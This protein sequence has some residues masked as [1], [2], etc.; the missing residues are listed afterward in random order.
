MPR[1]K[2][3]QRA[4]QLAYKAKGEDGGG[5]GGGGGGT[6]DADLL[7]WVRCEQGADGG[8]DGALQPAH[9]DGVALVDDAVD[10]DDV[11]GGAQPLH[12]LDLKHGTLQLGDVRQPVRHHRLRQ[13]HQQLQQVR[14]ALAW[15]QINTIIISSSGGMS[16]L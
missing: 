15:Q 5:G 11:D 4:G 13:L 16:A 12:D 6:L 2:V 3:R 14:D 9:H 10:E 7:H 8:D 1:N